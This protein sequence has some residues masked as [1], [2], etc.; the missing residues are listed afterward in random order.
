M[1]PPFIH[2]SI[3]SKPIYPILNQWWAYWT[4]CSLPSQST[5]S[6]PSLPLQSTPSLPHPPLPIHPY[7][8]LLTLLYWFYC[9]IGS[10][11]IEKFPGH[12]LIISFSFITLT[13]AKIMAISEI[14]DSL[15]FSV[16][17]ASWFWANSKHSSPSL[18]HG[19]ELIVNILLRPSLMFQSK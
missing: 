18:S 12:F 8:Y 9:R 5:P 2:P 13:Q 14:E 16:L 17:V 15:N 7:I 4:P 10:R 11:K 1:N 3:S 19:L 6:S